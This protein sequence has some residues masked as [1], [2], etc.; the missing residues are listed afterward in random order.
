MTVSQIQNQKESA[1]NKDKNPGDIAGAVDRIAQTLQTLEKF[2]ARRFDEISMEIN[3]TSQQVDMAEEGIGER[4]S[5]ILN[6]LHAISFKGDGKTPANTGAEL[7]TVVDMT[8]EAANQILDA[9]GRINTL[10]KSEKDWSDDDAREQM[11]NAINQNIEDIFVACSFQD[12]TSQRIRK[13]LENLKLIEDRLSV[14]LRKMG[15]DIEINELDNSSLFPRAKTQAEI[16]E[17]IE[18]SKP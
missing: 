3:A 1:K 15:I 2:M 7:D 13:T 5:Q 14:A 9:A 10:I 16:D 17:I 4:F 18:K 11:L 12:I 6:V 8:E